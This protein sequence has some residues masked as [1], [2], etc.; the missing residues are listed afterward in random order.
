MTG[1]PLP[2]SC[3]LMDEDDGYHSNRQSWGQPPLF[4]WVAGWGMGETRLAR[5]SHGRV[6]QGCASFWWGCAN[7]SIVVQRFV[8]QQAELPRPKPHQDLGLLDPPY[9]W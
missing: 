2:P 9:I 8:A 3:S 7:R 5:I 1:V 4:G 6:G